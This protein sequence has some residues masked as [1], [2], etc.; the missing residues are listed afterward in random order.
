MKPNVLVTGGSQGIGRAIAQRL[1]QDGLRVV[2]FDLRAPE[3]L[4]PDE[5][6]VQVDLSD[7]DATRQ[8][9][10]DI[11]RRDAPLRLVNNA[12]I[13]RPAP[14]D[15]ATPQD[16]AA[17]C[18]LKLRAP[19]LLLQGLLPAM[20]EQRFGRVVNISSR[21]ALGKGEAYRYPKPDGQDA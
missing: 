4:L 12:G 6:Y 1:T 2:N 10:A 3:A 21:A 17:V 18:A 20:R 15:E 7:I 11:A 8:A 19:M 13:V 16:L 9:V 14:L 5:T